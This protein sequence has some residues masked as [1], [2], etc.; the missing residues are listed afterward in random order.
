MDK[1]THPDLLIPDP[2]RSITGGCFVKEAFRYNP[3]TWDGR[4]MYSLS[5]AQGFSLDKPW[6]MLTDRARNAILYGIE[7]K[8]VAMATPPG[9]KGE[10]DKWEG[11]EVAFTRHRPPHRAAGTAA[12]ASAARPTRG[13]RRGS[14]R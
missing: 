8:K 7:P 4:L 6:N 12:T 9:A 5:K 11:K 13:W 3:D 10:H 14:T 1:L 2:K